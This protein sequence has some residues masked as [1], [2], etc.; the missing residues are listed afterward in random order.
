MFVGREITS[1]PG[2]PSAPNMIGARAHSGCVQGVWVRGQ[3]IQDPCSPC[4]N[5]VWVYLSAEWQIAR[6]N[7]VRP[8]R[9]SWLLW[10]VLYARAPVPVARQAPGNPVE[11][12]PPDPLPT[13]RYAGGHACRAQARVPFS[14][15]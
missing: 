13:S 14:S 7:V 10:A 5:R 15:T 9:A 3:F 8:S 2:S 4:L 1:L 6:Y 12:R 11:T